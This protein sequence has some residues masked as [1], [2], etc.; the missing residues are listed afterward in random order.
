MLEHATRYPD[1]EVCGLVGGAGRKPLNY[2]PIKNIAK[3]QQRSFLMDPEEQIACMRTMREKN[4]IMMGIFHSHP[5]SEAV[6]SD[7]DL[8][9][10]SY[11]HTIYFIASLANDMPELSAYYFEGRD[12]EK[13]TLN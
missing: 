9:L 1:I 11:P 2:Y 7:T 12:F 13:I 4:E 8:A 3:F 5:D 10:A 6:P